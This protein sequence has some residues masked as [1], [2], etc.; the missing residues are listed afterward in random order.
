MLLSL[1]KPTAWQLL[2]PPTC[3][4]LIAL[5]RR[6]C[7]MYCDKG[8]GVGGCIPMCGFE[9]CLNEMF[10]IYKECYFVC[11][12]GRN[13]ATLIEK[14]ILKPVGLVVY[15]DYVYWI[16]E[17]TRN[18]IKVKK[19]NDSSREPVQAYVDDLS[20]IAIVDITTSTGKRI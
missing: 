8:D 11:F 18:V 7:C 20:D 13:R 5:Q 10:V 15:K 4:K 1:V 3:Q 9:V 2:E 16:D 19:Y 17:D 12:V 6:L 14:N